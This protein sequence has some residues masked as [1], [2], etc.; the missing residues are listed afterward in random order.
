MA[1]RA[2]PL[3]PTHTP[4]SSFPVSLSLSLPLSFCLW[5]RPHHCQ[6][7]LASLVAAHTLTRGTLGCRRQGG[8]R[9]PRGPRGNRRSH[10]A[11]KNTARTWAHGQQ[12]QCARN[13]V[14]PEPQPPSAASPPGTGVRAGG[15]RGT[16]PAASWTLSRKP[17]TAPGVHRK[18]A[19]PP[20]RSGWNRGSCAPRA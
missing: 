4:A 11:F 10:W 2:A 14:S 7:K 16:A 18:H 9:P 15:S 19:G 8:L 13:K 20:G 1:L 5:A 3:S 6:S 12:N 17:Q